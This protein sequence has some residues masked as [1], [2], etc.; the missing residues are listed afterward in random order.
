MLI[1]TNS[2]NRTWKKWSFSLK[3]LHYW[4]AFS[5]FFSIILGSYCS[6]CLE[7]GWTWIKRWKMELYLVTYDHFVCL[8][9]WIILCLITS[10]IFLWDRQDNDK[11]LF[12]INI[13]AKISLTTFRVW[14]L[15]SALGCTLVIV[16]LTISN[17]ITEHLLTNM[18]ALFID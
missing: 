6:K 4:K 11:T 18:A 15:F 14:L 2:N 3:S 1:K 7:I 17:I 12:K 10:F 8:G 9:T 13:L 5:F 16:N